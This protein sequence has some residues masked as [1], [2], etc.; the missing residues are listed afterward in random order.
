MRDEADD[1]PAMADVWDVLGGEGWGGP[2]GQ[3]EGADVV[4]GSSDG[5][6]AV[7]DRDCPL[8]AGGGVPGLWLAQRPPADCDDEV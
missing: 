3:L 5:E 8:L 2:A 1:H 4:G 6:C 7:A